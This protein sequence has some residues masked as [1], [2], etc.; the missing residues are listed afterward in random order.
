MLK[1]AP[2]LSSSPFWQNNPAH[3]KG[4][5]FAAHKPS[6]HARAKEKSKQDRNNFIRPAK[7]RN[8]HEKQANFPFVFHTPSFP[9]QPLQCK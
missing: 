9:L 1:T 4:K 7:L 5:R 3:H 2:T 8:S 6:F